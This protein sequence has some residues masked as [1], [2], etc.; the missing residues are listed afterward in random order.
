[1]CNWYEQISNRYLQRELDSRCDIFVVT[2]VHFNKLCYVVLDEVDR[3]M[4]YNFA[5]DITNILE[6][7]SCVSLMSKQNL[8]FSSTFPPE[9]QQYFSQ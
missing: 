4:E 2:Y 5:N 7:P 9:P 8:L 1:M 6:S 3:L